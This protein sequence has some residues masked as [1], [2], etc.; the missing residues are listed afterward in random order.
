MKILKNR[1]FLYIA[2]F[3]YLKPSGFEN[4]GLTGINTLFNVLRIFCALII[5]LEYVG[6]HYRL[7]KL[8]IVESCYFGT[9][10]CSYFI[11]G[12]DYTEIKRFLILSISIVTFSMLFDY[13][14]KKESI[15]GI[16]KA[17]AVVYSI[18]LWSNL[19]LVI[20]NYGWAVGRMDDLYVSYSFLASDNSTAGYI[21]P[22]LL[23]ITLFFNRK[24]QKY[25]IMLLLEFT[26]I[27][28]TLF[29][30]WSAT[31]LVGGIGFL[32][33][34]VI[35]SQR[36]IEKFFN[37]IWMIGLDVLLQIGITFFSI[38]TWFSYIIVHVLN[39]SLAMTGRTY[40]WKKGI[41]DFLTSPIIGCG[42]ELQK[43]YID[44]TLIQTL[45]RGGLLAMIFLGSMI[46]LIACRLKQNQ[47]FS[48]IQICNVMLCLI[49]I[50]CITETWTKFI[51]FYLVLS[52]CFNCKYLT[53]YDSTYNKKIKITYKGKKLK[54]F[55]G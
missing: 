7:S 25:S 42:A 34:Y 46:I 47:K 11:N 17:L 10:L 22:A 4:G 36:N 31:M 44:S 35:V 54:T 18:F 55:G 20:K 9:I 32:L 29:R 21:F 14:C 23:V 2:L 30:M 41:S 16:L 51:G 13:Y 33:Y 37:I 49:L 28:L 50:M 19:L 53:N 24:G 43:Y 8:V 26:C 48:N 38:Q 39:K 6:M 45:R 40:L 5:L 12:T 1:L 52:I 3:A 15:W 27:Y